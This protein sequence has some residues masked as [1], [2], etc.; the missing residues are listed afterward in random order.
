[1]TFVTVYRFKVW[2]NDVGDF[3]VSL[4]MGTRAAIEMAQGEI[5]EGTA[6]EV[7]VAEINAEGLTK[8]ALGH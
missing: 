1:M 3:V 2:N 7:P 5:I 6:T 8:R 4:R